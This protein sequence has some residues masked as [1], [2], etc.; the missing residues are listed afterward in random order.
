MKLNLTIPFFIQ[1][2]VIIHFIKSFLILGLS[3]FHFSLF[4]CGGGLGSPRV[5]SA[6]LFLPNHIGL[7]ALERRLTEIERGGFSTTME[8]K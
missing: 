6:G 1:A 7:M 8:N 4:S 3:P 2:V 5:A